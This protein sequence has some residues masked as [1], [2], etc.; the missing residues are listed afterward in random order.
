MG[1]FQRGMDLMRKAIA[2]ERLRDYSPCSYS[3][4]ILGDGHGEPIPGPE[5]LTWWGHALVF[6]C[7]P[8]IFSE[9]GECL[10]WHDFTI[11]R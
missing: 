7:R 6:A 3:D 10:P 2:T 1:D 8:A 5:C 4:L 11:D 9:D